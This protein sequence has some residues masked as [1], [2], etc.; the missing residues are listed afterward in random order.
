MAW[1]SWEQV[2]RNDR[3]VCR[4]EGRKEGN[5]QGEDPGGGEREGPGNA[6][7]RTKPRTL[8]IH[9]HHSRELLRGMLHRTVLIPLQMSRARLAGAAAAPPSPGAALP[10]SDPVQGGDARVALRDGR[11]HGIQVPHAEVH[12]VVGGRRGLHGLHGGVAAVVVGVAGG[13]VVVG[14][15]GVG[16]VAVGVDADIVGRAVGR[17]FPQARLPIAHQHRHRD[18]PRRRDPHHFQR[19]VLSLPFAFVP[20]VLEPDFH[21]RGGEL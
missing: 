14:V 21:L 18:P 10:G 15:R 4:K 5:Y 13:A 12:E 8:P 17:G 6:W 16:V 20:S 1:C 7:P 3:L 2:E 19:L 11:L 9:V